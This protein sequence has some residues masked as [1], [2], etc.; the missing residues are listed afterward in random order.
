ME[1]TERLQM[2]LETGQLPY[3]GNDNTGIGFED[4]R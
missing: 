4:L 2:D 3:T 1:Q